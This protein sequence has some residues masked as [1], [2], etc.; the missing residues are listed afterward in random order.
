MVNSE[1]T[2]SFGKVVPDLTATFKVTNEGVRNFGI[3]ATPPVHTDA[4]RTSVTKYTY[5]TAETEVEYFTLAAVHF[6]P[7]ADKRKGGISFE[8]VL[9]AG[10]KTVHS[11]TSVTRCAETDHTCAPAST[12]ALHAIAVRCQP[13]NARAGLAF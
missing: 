8:G 5:M 12:S 4:F 9:C 3:A 1:A 6:S 13:Y 7:N 2:S 11:H 10:R